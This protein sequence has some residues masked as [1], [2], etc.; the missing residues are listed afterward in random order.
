MTTITKAL[1]YLTAIALLSSGSVALGQQL[2]SCVLTHQASGFPTAMLAD[3]ANLADRRPIA[4]GMPPSILWID[5]VHHTDTQVAPGEL[6][7]VLAQWPSPIPTTG[8]PLPPMTAMSTPWPTSLDGVEVLINGAP[9]AAIGYVGPRRDLP[10]WQQAIPNGEAMIQLP[11]D[12]VGSVTLQIRQT[13]SDGKQC[14]GNMLTLPVVPAASSLVSDA[15]GSP[16]VQQDGAVS[17]LYAVGMGGLVN[18]VPVGTPANVAIEVINSPYVTVDGAPVPVLYA[19]A[20]PGVVGLYQINLA[21]SV[22]GEVK[23]VQG[24]QTLAAHVAAST[25]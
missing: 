3:V 20:T 21:G 23:I 16:L 17:V 7:S 8:D 25:K 18:P 9:R 14:V 6:L 4:V 10:I 13:A 1:S 5:K 22:A 15:S 24:G 19:G 2:P 11:P 12:V